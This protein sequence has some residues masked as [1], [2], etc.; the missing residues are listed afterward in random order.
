MEKCLKNL[1][2]VFPGF[3]FNAES[4]TMQFT[5]K[6]QSVFF[7]VGTEVV[8]NCKCNSP[9]PCIIDYRHQGKLA[10]SF[11]EGDPIYMEDNYFLR[12]YTTNMGKYFAHWKKSVVFPVILQC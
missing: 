7:E 11:E 8:F 12:N 2:V 10:S 1:N 9:S 5:V 4:G 3:A 6:P